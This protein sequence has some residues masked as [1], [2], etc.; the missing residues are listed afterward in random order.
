MPTPVDRKSLTTSLEDRYKTQKA[1]GAFNA[2]IA[3]T[4]NMIQ[5]LQG[6]M[7]YS[8][9]SRKLTIEPGFT[10]GMA[11]NKQENFKDKVLGDAKS[12]GEGLYRV[13]N[14]TKYKP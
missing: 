1:G 6:S 12:P 4:N 2:K 11:T 14:T 5:G 10:T 13:T 7:G 9:I 8:D 3:N